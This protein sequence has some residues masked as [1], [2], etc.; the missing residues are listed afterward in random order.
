MG[1]EKQRLTL[2]M[3]G[4]LFRRGEMATLESILTKKEYDDL[5]PIVPY[6]YSNS[7]F[8][9]NTTDRLSLEHFNNEIHD[10]IVMLRGNVRYL[11]SIQKKVNDYNDK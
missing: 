7:I 9:V 1:I 5:L 2:K 3:R 4:Y 10:L 11:E 6:D 8:R